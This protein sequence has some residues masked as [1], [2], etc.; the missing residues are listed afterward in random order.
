MAGIPEHALFW[1]EFYDP[2]FQ[3]IFSNEPKSLEHMLSVLR[4]MYTDT[5][6]DDP[7]K[8]WWEKGLADWLDNPKDVRICFKEWD[9]VLF[10]INLEEEPDTQVMD[11]LNSIAPPSLYTYRSLFLRY[12]YRQALTPSDL[13]VLKGNELDIPEIKRIVRQSHEGLQN[14]KNF[15]VFSDKNKAL[16][17]GNKEIETE[18]SK[19]WNSKPGLKSVIWDVSGMDPEIWVGVRFVELDYPQDSPEPL[20]GLAQICV[21]TE[22]LTNPEDGPWAH[23]LLECQKRSGS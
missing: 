3:R 23:E 11:G 9:F 6:K 13:V 22:W 5:D 21:V 17:Y 7:E 15:R 10:S 19:E 14:D 16:D 12:D 18:H 2:P 4:R 1:V 20:R 8:K